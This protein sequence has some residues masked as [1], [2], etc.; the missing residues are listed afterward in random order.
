MAPSKDFCQ[1]GSPHKE[2]NLPHFSDYKTPPQNLGGK[3][4]CVLESECSLPGSL[5]GWGGG[6]GAGS[7]EAGAGPH[8]LL[9]NLFSYF[10]PLKPMCILWS[11][12]SYS[13]KSTVLHFLKFSNYLSERD[14]LFQLLNAF[15]EFF[16][17]FR[18]RNLSVVPVFMHSFNLT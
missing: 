12:V 2:K 16:S 13:P 6:S 4:G 8:F 7:Q 5:G 1:S 11:S 17:N 3:G 15:I 10:P 14:L 9:Q 18:E